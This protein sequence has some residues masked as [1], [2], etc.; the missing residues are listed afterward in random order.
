MVAMKIENRF[1]ILC[2][3]AVG[4]TSL[5]FH[6]QAIAQQRMADVF[7]ELIDSDIFT[8]DFD[9]KVNSYTHRFLGFPAVNQDFD[10]LRYEAVQQ[11]L[12]FGSQQT[13]TIQRLHEEWK[14]IGTELSKTHPAH[15]TGHTPESAEK[16]F[17]EA[18]KFLA[19]APDRL[20]GLLLD[21]QTERFEEI[22]RQVSAR[23]FGMLKYLVSESLQEF[24]DTNFVLAQKKTEL[25]KIGKSEAE[26]IR[27]DSKKLVLKNLNAILDVLDR[28]QKEKLTDLVGEV[29]EWAPDNVDIFRWQ[30]L[31][32]KQNN[33]E[34]FFTPT[35]EH[36]GLRSARF[37]LTIVGDLSFSVEGYQKLEPRTPLV[38]L[39]GRRSGPNPITLGFFEIT[40]QQVTE[41]NERGREFIKSNGQM[42][43]K[44]FSSTN[45]D[46]ETWDDFYRKSQ[47][48]WERFDR[49]IERVLSKDQLDKLE[50]FAISA[51]LCR[52]GIVAS[53][54]DGELGRKIEVS[55]SQIEEVVQ[56]AEDAQEQLI[57]Q[58]LEWE[59]DTLKKLI[60]V[61]PEPEQE[62]IEDHFGRRLNFAVGNTT[63]MLHHL[64]SFE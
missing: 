3:F 25:A 46:Q 10:L 14:D 30:L 15:A 17:Q 56:I 42:F 45:N 52:Y 24:L 36:R 49:E 40:Q 47:V 60:S 33:K 59:R 19:E 27:E 64:L 62:M 23:K 16:V 18:D 58:T 44:V 5:I 35:E 26:S 55:E 6:S 38:R 12:E 13:K 21:F 7:Y 29:E 11:D 51:E 28:K 39:L 9:G 31:Y 22:K 50:N 63:V 41:I 54:V 2:F 48:N 34:V 8:L 4:A 61:F 53:L 57:E 43:D 20:S 32:R 1:R 37:S